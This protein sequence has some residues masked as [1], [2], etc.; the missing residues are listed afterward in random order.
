MQHE[1]AGQP[2]GAEK[3]EEPFPDWNFAGDVADTVGNNGL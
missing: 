2:K 3:D 1:G